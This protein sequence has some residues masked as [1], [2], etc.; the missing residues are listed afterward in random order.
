MQ[1]TINRYDSCLNLQNLDRVFVSVCVLNCICVDVCECVDFPL[2]GGT[3]YDVIS[4]RYTYT[5]RVTCK[6]DTGA[7]I[8]LHIN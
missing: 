6:Y 7:P 3:V 2:L 8:Y 5:V 4:I 1:D